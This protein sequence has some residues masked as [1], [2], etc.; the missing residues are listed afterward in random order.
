VKV[1][2]GKLAFQHVSEFQNFH[3]SGNWKKL[4]SA[5]A[6]EVFREFGSGVAPHIKM[7][8]KPWVVVQVLH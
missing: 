5:Q 2:L 6:E 1:V 4:I 7:M 8:E 3:Q